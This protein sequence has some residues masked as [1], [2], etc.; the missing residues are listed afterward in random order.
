MMNTEFASTVFATLV[1]FVVIK[2]GGRFAN[3]IGLVDLP[4]SRKHHQGAVPLI[5]GVAIY[6]VILLSSVLFQELSG[7]MLYYLVAAGV[8]VVV[9]MLDDYY[10][11]PVKTRIGAQ[12]LVGLIMILGTGNQ[13]DSLGNLLAVGNISLGSLSIPFT[14]IGVLGLINAYN[15]VD[16]I[17]GL[18]AGLSILAFS[19]IVVLCHGDLTASVVPVQIFVVALAIFLVFNMQLVSTRF[20]K[21]FLGDAGSML[22]GFSLAWILI[23]LT[24][25]TNH[26]KAF[27]P[28][29]ALW[30]VGL[31]LMDMVAVTL[32]RLSRKRSPFKPDREHLHHIL[33]YIGYSDREALAI[34]MVLAVLINILGVFLHFFEIDENI[35][36]LIFLLVYVVYAYSLDRAGKLKQWR[37][38]AKLAKY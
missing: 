1:S 17:D 18:S 20:K 26:Q 29:V 8:L 2:S 12:L 11:L 24:Q 22:I 5:G 27:E 15:M 10:E 38:N 34:I 14:L 32:R 28:V 23:S 33:Q 31:P 36:F 7:E 6:L 13:V 3:K 21:V 4:D 35:S 9:G 25:N 30:I 19:V 16:G 37:R